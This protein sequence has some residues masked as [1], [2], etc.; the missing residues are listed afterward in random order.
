MT[1]CTTLFE[2]KLHFVYKKCVYF[3]KVNFSEIKMKTANLNF[4]TSESFTVNSCASKFSD[5]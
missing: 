5:Y 1:F 3:L 4:V 2:T